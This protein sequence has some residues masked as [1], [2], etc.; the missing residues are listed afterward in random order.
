MLQYSKYAD[1]SVDSLFYCLSFIGMTGFELASAI[2][3]TQVFRSP[4]AFYSAITA[5]YPEWR[6]TSP[7]TRWKSCSGSSRSGNSILTPTRGN[8]AQPV[9]E[10]YCYFSL[11]VKLLFFSLT[12]NRLGWDGCL[13][14]QPMWVILRSSLLE[15]QRRR[16][17]RNYSWQQESDGDV[18]RIPIKAI[19]RGKLPLSIKNQQAQL[20]I[21][22]IFF[23]C[24]NP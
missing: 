12:K 3:Q 1:S 11:M 4:S 8:W 2:H 6:S 7:C 10:N 9:N 22:I 23:F 21:K 14:T 17:T 24:G 16:M 18:C 19:W 13:E 5:R 20:K 15:V